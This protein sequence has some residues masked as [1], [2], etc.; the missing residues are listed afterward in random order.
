MQ[1]VT[2]RA[3][4]LAPSQMDALPVKL[5]HLPLTIELDG[6]TY[7]S[8]IDVQS[9]EFYEILE[10]AEGMPTTSLPAPGEVEQIYR[11][12]VE[13]T[14]DKDILSVHISQ[15]LSGTL[16]S[17]RV[18]AKAVEA[19]GINVHIVDTRTLSGAEGWQVE[20]AAYAIQAGWSLDQ[21]DAHLAKISSATRTV[22]TLP[23]LKYLIHGGRISH[24]SGLLANTLGIKPHIGVSY[25][26]GKYESLGRVRTFKKAVTGLADT[27]AK[28]HAPGTKIRVQPLHALNPESM[29]SMKSALAAKFD[30]EFMADSA[31]APVLGAHTG[32]GLVGCA[33]AAVDDLPERPS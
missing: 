21:I 11:Q 22:Y 33:F 28:R 8:G 31:I 12:V 27:I 6:K 5:Y 29:E 15:G 7:I 14:G 16:N 32:S 10:G 18:A 19:D 3:A 4:D 20:A 26:T 9:L 30:V 24:I 25:E 1:L 2:D 23:T 13:E 17:V